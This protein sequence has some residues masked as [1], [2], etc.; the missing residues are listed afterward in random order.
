MMKTLATSVCMAA[1][2]AMAACAATP[3]PTDLSPA[4]T[5]E[6]DSKMHA[7][8]LLDRTGSMNS[9][10]DEALA[11]VNTYAQS[12]GTKE[13]GEDGDVDADVTLAVFD[14]QDGLAFDVLR[15]SASAKE[16]NTVTDDEASPR[17]MTPLF[18][19]IGRMVGIAEV[20]QPDKAVI[21]IMTD[22]QENS[23]RELTREGA[24]AALDRA[25]EKGWE[26]V[27]LGAE[28][29]N[30]GDAES[31]GQAQSK[32]MAVSKDKL[33]ITM[34]RLAK[35]SRDYAKGQEPSVV[36]DEE[37]RAIAEEEDV[38]QRKGQ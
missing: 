33:G 26:V 4:I 9:I 29:A 32:N 2:M 34:D 11:S 20:D 1:S 8:I 37:D 17:G 7:Y 27:F 6:E 25:R 3:T 13:E 36:F 16:W 23:S 21:V 12:L 5:I 18:D 24:K 14:A 28:F 22:G 15:K 38:K 10:W 35:K 31:V 30:F 19:A